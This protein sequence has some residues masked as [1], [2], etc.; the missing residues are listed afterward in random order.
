MEMLINRNILVVRSLSDPSSQQINLEKL[1]V[2]KIMNNF[3]LNNVQKLNITPSI[4]KN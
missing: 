4:S 2:E 3:E 1:S